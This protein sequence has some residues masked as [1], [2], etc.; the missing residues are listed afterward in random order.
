M[1][2]KDHLNELKKE[3]YKIVIPSVILFFTFFALAKPMILF[4]LNFYKIPLTSVVSLT[5]FESLQTSLMVAGS[6]TI[7]FLLPLILNGMIRYSREAIGEKIYKATKK[8]IIT[9]YSLAIFGFVVGLLLFSKFI[10]TSL[11]TDYT[12][13]TAQWSIYSVFSFI[14]ISS[15]SLAIAMQMIILIPMFVKIGLIKKETL[16]K[17]RPFAFI[18]VLITSAIITPTT[19]LISMGLMS[20][21]IYGAYELGIMFSKTKLEDKEKC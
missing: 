11:I 20:L 6:L 2:V 16:K 7:L 14:I 18:I 8:L 1:K 5:P 12:I 21:P 10:L 17:I 13:T 9:S 15:I 4:I 3:L 19:D